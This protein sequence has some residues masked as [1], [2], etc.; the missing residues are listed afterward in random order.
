MLNALWLEYVFH[1]TLQALAEFFLLARIE[2]RPE[3][4]APNP[5]TLCMH[6]V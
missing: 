4:N 6:W 1:R 5:P 3:G 2:F